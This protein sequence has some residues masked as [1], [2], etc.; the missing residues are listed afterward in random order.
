MNLIKYLFF[1]IILM[2]QACSQDG[3]QTTELEGAWS[4]TCLQSFPNSSY[5]IFDSASKQTIT[6]Y[7]SNSVI[8]K[9]NSYADSNCTQ[10][11]SSV[12]A[13]QSG[14]FANPQDPLVSFKI[15]KEILSA[16]GVTVKQI[17]FYTKNNVIQ[18]DIYLLLNN[19]TTLYLGVPCSISPD[20]CVGNR[21]T[22]INYAIE[23]TKT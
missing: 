2:F 11:E 22:E 17:D 19:D 13:S 9:V 4:S 15:G 8:S 1:V 23:Y 21:P 12:D 7:H 10:L 3:T 20:Q 6:T 18:P 14:L 5:G 16:N